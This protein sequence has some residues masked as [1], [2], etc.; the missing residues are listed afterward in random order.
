MWADNNIEAAKA[1]R[2]IDRRRRD[3]MKAVLMEAGVPETLA[4]TRSQLLYWIYLGA[5]LSRTKLSGDALDQI[6][7]ELKQI[8]LGPAPHPKLAMAPSSDAAAK[9]R[10]SRR[11]ER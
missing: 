8:S 11:N 10:R 3:Y 2:D 7:Q 9:T 6:I 4:G 1:I 5:A